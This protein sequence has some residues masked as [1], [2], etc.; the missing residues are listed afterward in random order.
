MMPKNRYSLEVKER[1][2]R[3][4]GEHRSQYE[5]EWAAIVS[6]ATKIGCTPES[7]RVWIRQGERDKGKHPGPYTDEKGQIKVLERE[8]RELKRANEILHLAS[9]FSHRRNSTAN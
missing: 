5:S 3:M 1:A 7:L 8:V 9:A 2:V 4:V 6:I